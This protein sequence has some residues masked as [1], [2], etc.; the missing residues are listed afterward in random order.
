M[1]PDD[2]NEAAALPP[3][4]PGTP[5]LHAATL[6]CENCGHETPHRI[7]R[8]SSAN[9]RGKGHL[10]GTA[11]CRRCDWT[12]RFDIAVPPTVEVAE[13]VS[14]GARS[15][16]RQVSLPVAARIELGGRVPGSDE[17]FEVHRIETRTGTSV[18][19]A[20]PAE[21]VTLWVTRNVGAHVPVSVVEGARTW[22]D[23]LTIPK[24][25]RL[26]VGDSLTVRGSPLRIV[27]LRARGRTWRLPEDG[28]AALEVQRVYARRTDSPPAGR[29]VWRSGRGS[30]RSRESD[31]S[32]SG[33]ER[34]G[35]GVRRTRS[36]P[37]SRNAE[38]GATIHRVS[39]R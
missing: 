36:L 37:R 11:R 33:R 26:T 24:S 29:R 16:R 8:L 25:S 17:A 18:S 28:F 5:R 35:P 9:V 22:T 4:G 12:H 13:V 19:S 32:S 3:T 1:G 39:P 6:M 20:R 2:P 23:R 30:P 15:S 38:G 10:A 27:A 31:S 14:D 34:S 7:L 21:I